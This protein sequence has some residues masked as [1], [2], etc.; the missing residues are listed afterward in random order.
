MED[1]LTWKDATAQA[2]LVR[3]GTVSPLELVDAAIER[4]DRCNPALN[5]VIHRRFDSARAEA[6]GELPNGPFRGVPILL[7][8]LGATQAGEPY[9]EGTAFARAAGY[10][11][12]TDSYLVQRFKRAGFV[13]LGR[14]NTPELGTSIT[15]EPLAFGATRNPWSTEHTSGGSSGGAAAAVASGMVPVA[16]ASDGGGSIRIPASCCALFG[17][18]PSRGRVSAG[19]AP[20]ESWWGLST[21]HVEARTVRDSAAVLDQIAGYLPGDTFVAPAP[22]RAF[23]Q[24]VGASPGSLRVGLLDHA[25]QPTYQVDPEC[26]RAVKLAGRLL[27]SLGHR[28]EHAH[29]AS[30]EEPEFQR[31]FLL[32]VATAV[33]SSLARWSVRLGREVPPEEFEPAN[34]L[35]ATLGRSTSAPDYLDSVLWL[36]GFR[37]RTYA[38]WSEQGFDLLCTPVLAQPPA[39]LGELSDPVEGQRRVLQTLQFTG[40]FNVSGQPAASLPLHWAPGGLPIGVQLVADYGREDVLFR[41]ASQLEAAAPWVGRRPPVHA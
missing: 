10:R 16:H 25:T 23:S 32:V 40:Q 22:A 35:F 3:Q 28:V 8:D 31:H 20:G 33:A 18:K 34:T 39:R 37:R 27:E 11:A 17:L 24:E 30:L 9:C 4:I 7:K 15:T 41:V 19:P 5:A 2:D 13:V 38:F 1:Q 29:P 12:E 36:E 14:T 21:N 26:A 6:I